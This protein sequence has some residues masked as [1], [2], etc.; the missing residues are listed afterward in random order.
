MCCFIISRCR[1]LY[2]EFMRGSPPFL[3]SLTRLDFNITSE[4]T[5]IAR[6]SWMNT[7]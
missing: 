5:C 1:M 6:F 3:V 4:A 2:R 7:K